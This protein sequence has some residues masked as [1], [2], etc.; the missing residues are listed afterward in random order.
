MILSTTFRCNNTSH[1]GEEIKVQRH[2]LSITINA[3]S[4][5]VQTYKK[6]TAHT[7]GAVGGVSETHMNN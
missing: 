4:V 6:T 1:Y 5:T 2:N 7:Y 3:I